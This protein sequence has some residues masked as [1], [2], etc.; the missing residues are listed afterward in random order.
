[1]S[2]EEPEDSEEHEPPPALRPTPETLVYRALRLRCPRC[3]QGKMFRTWFRMYHRC[4]VC[5]LLIDHPGS[6]YYLGSIYINYGATA[7]FTTISFIVGRL[8]FQV[9]AVPMGWFLGVFCIIFPCF[10]F[11]YSRALWLALDCQFDTAVLDEGREH[12]EPG[13]HPNDLQHEPEEGKGKE[14]KEKREEG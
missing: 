2:S 4:S 7:W 1:M 12:Q 13:E 8:Y 5:N 3:G 14:R 6:G 10:F 9:P 11:R